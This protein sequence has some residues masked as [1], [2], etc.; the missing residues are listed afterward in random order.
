M[1][2]NA[3]AANR[4]KAAQGGGDVRRPFDENLSPFLIPYLSRVLRQL[5]VAITGASGCRDGIPL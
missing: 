5:T 2:N 4:P 3:H 1:E